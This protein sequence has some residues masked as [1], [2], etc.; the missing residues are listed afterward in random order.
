MLYRSFY[1]KK[2]NIM[3][4]REEFFMNLLKNIWVRGII[5]ICILIGG[6][7]FLQSY[8]QVEKPTLVNTQGRAFEKATVVEVLKDNIQEDGS[9]VGDQVVLLQMETGPQKGQ[10]LEA[11]SPNGLL[12]GTACKPGLEV[13]TISSV[14]SISENSSEEEMKQAIK[15][16]ESYFVEQILKNVQESLK[17]DEDSSN[18]QLTEYFMEQVGETIADKIVDQVGN[19]LTQTLYE[20]MCRNYNIPQTEEAAADTTDAASAVAT[21]AVK[22]KE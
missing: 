2:I 7:F 13:I 21:G 15:D 9:R 19:R 18:A 22:E 14:S 6:F 8:N 10:I 5:I 17:D 16:F 3:I 12:F 11:N 20:Q 4:I 1:I